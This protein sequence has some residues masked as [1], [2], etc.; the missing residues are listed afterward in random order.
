VTSSSS[1]SKRTATPTSSSST[2]RNSRSPASPQ[3]TG[4]TSPPHSAPTAPASPS[5]Q[6]AAV[7]GNCTSWRWLRATSPK[8]P[9]RPQ[10]DSAPSWSPDGQWLAFETY[11]ND[12]LEIA[13]V[14]VASGETIPLTQ[15]PASDHSP[16]WAPDG[17]N[18]AFISTRG[19]DSDVWLANL[20]LTGDDR[21]QNLSNTPFAAESSPRLEYDGSQLLWSSISQTVGFSG[22]YVW[23]SATPN[24]AAYWVGDGGIGT[25]NTTADQVAAIHQRAQ[26]ILPHLLRSGWKPNP[27]IHPLSG[28]V[29]GIAWGFAALPVALPNSYVQAAALTPCR[30]MVSRRHPGRRSAEP[31]LVCRPN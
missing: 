20:D 21:Y 23:D 5:P 26:S 19:G 3:A 27:R 16:A 8:S 25:W 15:H 1:P 11:L 7:T 12:N 6:T 18:V 22:L 9:T 13:V 28:R 29:R 31:A 17:R 2:R 4:T 24:R 14:N 30:V 10:Y